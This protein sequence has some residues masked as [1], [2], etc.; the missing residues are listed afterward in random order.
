MPCPYA[1]TLCPEP[2]LPH[3][4]NANSCRDVRQDGRTLCR[5]VHSSG[6]LVNTVG[7]RLG[8]IAIGNLLLE[9]PFAPRQVS[10]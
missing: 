5:A 4:I 7:E 10:A 9:Q 2:V 3:I 6:T 1:L 8:S